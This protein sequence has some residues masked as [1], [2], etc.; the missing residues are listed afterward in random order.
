MGRGQDE[1]AALEHD[2]NVILVMSRCRKANGIQLRCE[3]VV[4]NF[5]S[6]LCRYSPHA[7]EGGVSRGNA[8]TPC[9]VV[10]RVHVDDVDGLYGSRSMHK[11][12]SISRVLAHVC[13]ACS[14]TQTSLRTRPPLYYKGFRERPCRPKVSR[15]QTLCVV[16]KE[17]LRI[18]LL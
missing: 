10:S 14:I 18:Q 4:P 15:V 5:A 3:L 11:R 16:G 7:L 8:L 1:A 17:S 12:I 2:I 6:F 13:L 9:T